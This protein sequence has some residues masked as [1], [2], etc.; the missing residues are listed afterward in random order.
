VAVHNNMDA[1][2]WLRK[3]LEG[4]ESSDLLREMG[5]R[6]PLHELGEPRQGEA[7]HRRLRSRGGDR[8]RPRRSQLNQPTEAD[9]VVVVTPRAG[10]RPSP[11]GTCSSTGATRWNLSSLRDEASERQDGGETY[12]G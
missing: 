3:H 8:A 4:E 7:A 2:E 1:L 5:R 6:A 12:G 9:V 10:T 11:I